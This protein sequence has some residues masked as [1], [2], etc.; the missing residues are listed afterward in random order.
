MTSSSGSSGGDL[1]DGG[2]GSDTA[3]YVGSG[4]VSINLS[5]GEAKNKR[6]RERRPDQHRK[7]DRQ[8]QQRHIDRRRRDNVLEGGAGDD[9][10]NGGNHGASATRSPYANSG[11]PVTGQPG[12]DRT[13]TTGAGLDTISN[14]ENIQ[15]SQSATTDRNLFDNVLIGGAGADSS[16]RRRAGAIRLPIQFAGGVIASLIAGGT[17]AMPPAI[18]TPHRRI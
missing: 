7:R 16:R 11:V 4:A 17:R 8:L 1:L 13:T 15:G 12:C 2:E 10:L 14:F 3:S 5:S 6:R 9:L 18:P